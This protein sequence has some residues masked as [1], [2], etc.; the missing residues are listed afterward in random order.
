MT[1]RLIPKNL[2]RG[3]WCAV[4]L[5]CG[6]PAAQPQA[7]VPTAPL[8]TAGISGQQVGI[9]PITL[10]AAEDTLH[11]DT[12]VSERDKAD[13]VLTT[14]LKARAPEVGWVSPEELR[15]MARRAPGIATDPEQMATPLLRD[16]RMVQVVDPLRNQL[17]TLAAIAG[18]MRYVLAPAGLVYRR[19]VG[20]T[21]GR[22]DHPAAT[23]EI[24]VVLVDVRLGR[25]AWRT[26][27]RGEAD[28]PWTAL[29]RA[30]KALTPGLP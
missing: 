13:S 19:T 27:A 7:P 12:V 18:G 5:A 3:A 4:A 1:N 14:L 23:A 26:V 20:L 24:T 8:P 25:V 2:V 28:D 11:W 21:D 22:T 15:R 16:P 17:R 9:L 30:V 6:H 10:I 29:T